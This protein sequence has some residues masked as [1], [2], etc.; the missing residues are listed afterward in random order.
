MEE[1][2]VVPS[3]PPLRRGG[4]RVRRYKPHSKRG[5]N[6]CKVRKVKCGEEKPSCLRCTST[7]RTCEGH[8]YGEPTTTVPQL[9]QSR[10]TI[11][12]APTREPT[13][14]LARCR[15]PI[16]IRNPTTKVFDSDQEHCSFKFFRDVS[17]NRLSAAFPSKFWEKV[18]LQAC[19]HEP[20]IRH[21]AAAL[22]GLHMVSTQKK[23]RLPYMQDAEGMY[24]TFSEF[25]Y[26]K[27]L[28]TLAIPL[29]EKPGDIVLMTCL[30]FTY[31]EALRGN[32]KAVR[33]HINNGIKIVAELR[34][35]SSP[36]PD[37]L[38][39]ELKFTHMPLRDLAL[40]FIKNDGIDSE[41]ITAS[42]FQ[43]EFS[44]SIVSSES[45][46]LLQLYNLE[47]AHSALNE[48]RNT[49]INTIIG[50]K[51]STICFQ[52]ELYAHSAEFSTFRKLRQYS[53]ALDRFSRVYSDKLDP[54]EQQKAHTLKLKAML[55]GMDLTT[56]LGGTL[57]DELGTL[58]FKWGWKC[59]EIVA[60]AEAAV[61]SPTSEIGPKPMGL[62]GGFIWPLCFAAI[63]YRR[64]P[65]G[66]RAIELLRTSE[67]REGVW[68]SLQAADLVE[69][70]IR[71]E[72]DGLEVLVDAVNEEDL[73]ARPWDP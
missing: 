46:S 11:V 70:L 13:Y 53:M 22:G 65:L 30:L 9:L 61:R 17:R 57:K 60:Y 26:T 21:A 3:D 23:R 58:W 45:D 47:Q 32:H 34:A 72:E 73:V 2:K 64:R 25:Q 5:C 14:P 43:E 59:Q 35:T 40:I 66:L 49:A 56:C 1:N 69:H 28:R 27:A 7:G 4:V 67:M 29:Q 42:T 12:P 51:T 10:G 16:L 18:I 8:L 6:T 36:R 20:A 55:I 24:D 33:F 54:T 48:I 71:R 37:N 15:G 44:D 41:L 62:Y 38:F 39:Y 19:H 31:F 52:P 50:S 68:N 63:R